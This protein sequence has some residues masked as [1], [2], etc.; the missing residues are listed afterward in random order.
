MLNQRI[1][2]WRITG[3]EGAEAAPTRPGRNGEVLD[4]FLVKLK[5]KRNK[6]SLVC[7]LCIE[8]EELT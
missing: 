5:P 6:K 3:L 7:S 8:Y 4:K 2:E 1:G